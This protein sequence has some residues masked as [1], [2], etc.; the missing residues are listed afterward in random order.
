MMRKK[1]MAKEERKKD[2]GVSKLDSLPITTVV[3]ND[4]SFKGDIHGD[5]IVR[6]DGKVEGNISS[7]QGIILGEKAN[8]EGSLESDNVIIFGHIKGS[9][10]SKELI[11]KTTGSVQGD[12]VSDFLEVEMGSKYDGSLKIGQRE[13]H[14]DTKQG[15]VKVAPPGIEPGSTV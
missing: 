5:G 8:V 2:I 4:M 6:I 13:I 1:F 3:G 15:K 9:I 11:L 14:D 10:K 7:K 12:I